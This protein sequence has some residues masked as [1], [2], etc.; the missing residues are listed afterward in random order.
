MPEENGFHVELRSTRMARHGRLY[1]SIKVSIF[2]G[3]PLS[4]RSCTKSQFHTS[5]S[6][7]APMAKAVELPDRRWLVRIDIQLN[8]SR[9]QAM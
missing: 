3:T 6:E 5:L 2:T 9:E 1:S 7:F 8:Q 4:V